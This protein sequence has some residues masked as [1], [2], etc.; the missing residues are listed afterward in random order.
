M[1][2]VTAK[3]GRPRQTTATVAAVAR[4]S[5]SIPRLLNVRV[6]HSRLRRRKTIQFELWCTYISKVSDFV[7]LL[8]QVSYLSTQIACLKWG[9]RTVGRMGGTW[10]RI[11]SQLF[12]LIGRRNRW[13]IPGWFLLL[14][15][16][17]LLLIGKYIFLGLGKNRVT[18]NSC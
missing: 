15:R 18:W 1:P 17:G 8:A 6:T 4:P 2:R 3:T 13:A 14:G 10:T 5:G 7:K 12:L 9:W 16:A 11:P